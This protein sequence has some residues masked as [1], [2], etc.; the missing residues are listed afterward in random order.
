MATYAEFLSGKS[1][2]QKMRWLAS[3]TDS[4]G[5]SLSE[6]QKTVKDREARRAAVLGVAKRWTRLSD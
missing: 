6:L 5:L 4:T 3:I 1:Q 2:R